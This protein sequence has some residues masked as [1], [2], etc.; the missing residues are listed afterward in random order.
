MELLVVIAIIGVL[1]A[2]LLPAVQK[3]RE[4]AARVQC[5]NNL[6]QM[7]LAAQLYHDAHQV[8][9]PGYLGPQLGPGQGSSTHPEEGLW[10]GH[11]PMLLPYLEEEPL[12]RRLA[13]DFRVTAVGNKKWWWAQPAAGPG[14]P[15]VANYS[16]ATQRLKAFLCQSVPV[17]TAEANNPDLAAGGTFVGM[18]VYHTA[19]RGITTSGWRDE[20]GTAAAFRPLGITHYNGVAGTGLGTHPLYSLYEGVFT[21]RSTNP[22]SSVGIPDGTSNTLLYGEAS[23]TRWMTRP[24]TRNIAWMAGGGLGTY[25]GLGYG[26]ETTVP[27]F[28]SYHPGGVPFCFA[29]GSVRLLSR[30]TTAWSGNDSD[31]KGTGWIVLQ[32]LAGRRDGE[33]ADVDGLGQ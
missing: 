26:D 24:R 23:G 28:G 22:L 27:G 5:L 7:G 15:D 29:D 9:P 25:L 30:G 3:V 8:L 12:F 20:Y 6:K 10:V 13:I 31:P 11:F 14:E 19:E 4:A 33:Q 16:V 17:F 21:N 18:H 2:M 32:R 1:I